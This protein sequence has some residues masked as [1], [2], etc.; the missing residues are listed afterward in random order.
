FL[1]NEEFDRPGFE[2]AK[3]V[4]TPPLRSAD[5]QADLWR[6]LFNGDLSVV[7]TDHCPFCFE[8]D[9][10]YGLKFSKRQGE[11]EGFHKIPNGGPGIEHRIPVL[12]DGAVGKRGMSLNRFVELVATNPAKLFGMYPR[13]GT[14]AV[15]SDA[16]IVLFD[17]DESWTIRAA[18]QHSRVDYALFEG[19]TVRGRA[20]K[21]FLRGQLIVD[22]D[23]WLGREGMGE[24][25]H[26]GESGRL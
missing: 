3:Y 25:L 18:E 20:K 2:A 1:T 12:F 23:R 17:P 11:A 15:G 16:D 6:G 13:K 10:P 9:Q 26:R 21:V 4:F 22:G 8:E 14:I 24:F 7:S 19:F 5:H